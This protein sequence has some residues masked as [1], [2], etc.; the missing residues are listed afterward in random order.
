MHDLINNWNWFLNQNI[1]VQ[2]TI[3]VG[4][5]NIV[6]VGL[7]QLGFTVL[8]DNCQKLENALIAMTTAAKTAFVMELQKPIKQG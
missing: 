8:A 7:K 2:A 3:L 1:S 5:L 6:I 4:I